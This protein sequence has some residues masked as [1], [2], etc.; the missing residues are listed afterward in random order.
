MYKVLLV[1]DETVIRQGLRELIGQSTSQFGVTG[2][3]A[4]GMEALEYLKCE[5]PDLMITDI[6]MREMDGLTLAS[7]VKEM[8]P[9]LPVVII[10]G[11]GEFEYARKAI[12][13]GVSNYLLKPIERLELVSTLDKIK[14][15]LDQRHGIAASPPSGAKLN[16]P[17]ASGDARKIIRDVKEFVKLHTDG[18]LRLQTVAARVHL[19]ATYLS[20]L[21]KA[22]TGTNYSEYVS[23][24]RMERAKWLLA[25]TRLKIYDVA[26]LS[27][28]QSPKHFMLVFKQ[29]VGLT[30][31]DYRDQYGQSVP[32]E[33]GQG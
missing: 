9:D 12:E 31:G 1:E 27:G 30:A 21:F 29:Q 3:A 2:E 25:N 10:S 22:E 5:I 24:A 17:N 20:Q 19:N 26:R 14:L 28:H 15:S 16:E 13:F 7:K 6:R 8:Y 18:D 33:A 23:E 32:E 4:N 11:Y